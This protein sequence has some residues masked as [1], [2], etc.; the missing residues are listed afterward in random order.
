MNTGAGRDLATY[1]ARPGQRPAR[2]RTARPTYSGLHHRLRHA[3]GP[4]SARDCADE[5]CLRPA[6]DW[7]YLGG[8]PDELTDT[9]SGLRYS[10]DSARY[11]PLCRHHHRRMDARRAGRPSTFDVAEWLL[12]L[13]TEAGGWV[14]SDQAVAA[15]A[16]V[17]YSPTEV[18]RARRLL[19]VATTRVGC[20]VGHGSRYR[21]ALRHEDADPGGARTGP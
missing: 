21:W 16:H 17:G 1:E 13:L 11:L 8:D 20:R 10:L 6:Q 15:A 4:A 2:R 14:L 18:W 3:L 9:H 19:G 5:E 7:C 12:L